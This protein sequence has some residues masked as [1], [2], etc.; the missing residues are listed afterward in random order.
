MSVLRYPKSSAAVAVVVAGGIALGA[1]SGNPPA[2]R[3]WQAR[4]VAYSYTI[5]QKRPAY[6]VVKLEHRSSY[7]I[8]VTGHEPGYLCGNVECEPDVTVTLVE[9]RGYQFWV[10]DPFVHHWK[11]WL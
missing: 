1:T 2:L 5:A 8:A 6:T 9:R 4:R 3:G 11:R 7:R 10:R